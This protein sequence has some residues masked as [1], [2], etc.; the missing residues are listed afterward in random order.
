MPVVTGAGRFVAIDGESVTIDG[1]H[2]YVL[3]AASDGSH[4]I[5]QRGLTALQC[6]R[7]LLDVKHNNPDATFVGF[8]IDY[9]VNMML[10][11]IPHEV[12]ESLWKTHTARWYHRAEKW[13]LQWIPGKSFRVTHYPHDGKRE[14]IMI[15]NTF[16]FFQTKFVKALED[17]KIGAPDTIKRMKDERADFTLDQL[18]EITAYC[19]EECGLLTTLMERLYTALDAA[20]L[21]PARWDGAGAIAAQLLKREKVKPYIAPIDDYPVP[22]QEAIMR[23]YFGGRVELLQQGEFTNVWNYDIRSAYPSIATTL[24]DSHGSWQHARTYDDS[25]RWAVWHCRWRIP[26]THIVAPFPYRHSGSIHYCRFGEG[27]Y[28]ADEVR[29]AIRLHGDT[30]TVLEGWTFEPASE[31][32]PFDFVPRIYAERAEAKKAKH[33]K[34]KVLKLGL[35][36][37]YGKLAQGVGWHGKIPA[38]RSF[39]WAGLIT[40]GTRAKL[41][42]AACANASALIAFATD[43]ILSTEPLPTL[44]ERNELGFWESGQIASLFVAQ[45]GIYRAVGVD[46]SEIVK[47]RGFF[48]REID[49][50]DLIAGWRKFG[51]YYKQKREHVRFYGVGIAILRN[52]MALRCQWLSEVRSI[53]LSMTPRKFP[54]VP[55]NGH[56]NI[57]LNNEPGYDGLSAPYKPKTDGMDIAEGREQFIQGFEQ[58]TS[59]V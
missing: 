7:Y 33:P 27:W 59:P 16:G 54:P 32:K 38:Y 1:D 3:L 4:V 43:G 46:G 52:N 23:A 5:D 40:S 47:S 24:P 13:V 57:I 39:F 20:G 44:D 35:N 28:Y 31:V 18:E 55:L 51:P 48:A 12:I 45:P 34:E 30:I 49:F 19:H 58:P 26:E 21:L 29:N 6:F 8:A 56:R 25:E 15:Y 42:D 22:V 14:S 9:D 10:K 11:M 17:W 41:L 50:D 2:K 53:S 36:S 37:L